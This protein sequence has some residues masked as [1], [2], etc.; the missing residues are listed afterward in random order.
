MNLLTTVG[1]LCRVGLGIV[2]AGCATGAPPASVPTSV[3]PASPTSTAADV[4]RL[5]S[6]GE[7]EPGTYV[8][9][10]PP[11]AGVRQVTFD[12]P[13]GWTSDRGA[14]L[15]KEF[16][17]PPAGVGLGL[18]IIGDVYADPCAWLGSEVDP[19][20]TSLDELVA[21]FVSHRGASDPVVVSVDGYAGKRIELRVPDDVAFAD[22]D[23]GEFRSWTDPRVAGGGRFHQGPGQIDELYILDVEGT[24]LVIGGA[25]FPGSRR[26]DVDELHQMVETIRIEPGSGG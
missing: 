6:A 4:P 11:I 10:G 17:A 3:A 19:P 2:L 13:A 14:F 9:A 22:C 1:Q 23:R 26:E 12:I 7:V 5:P 25:H 16:A 18:W 24:V 21:A 8:Y 20:P 15:L